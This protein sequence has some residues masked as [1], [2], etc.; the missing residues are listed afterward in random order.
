MVTH[1]SRPFRYP[2]FSI[3][4]VSNVHKQVL[5]TGHAI[6]VVMVLRTLAISYPLHKEYNLKGR[7][8]FQLLVW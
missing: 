8:P 5:Q 2:L 4:S 3:K 6:I 1:K 7:T